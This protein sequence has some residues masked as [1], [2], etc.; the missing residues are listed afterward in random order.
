MKNY[1][2]Q[3]Q[4]DTV[5]LKVSYG[6]TWRG[7]HLTPPFHL[8]ANNEKEAEDIARQIIDPLN[9]CTMILTVSEE[10]SLPSELNAELRA[11]LGAEL[12]NA[13]EALNGDSKNAEHN[14]LFGLAKAVADV[15]G[16]NLYEL[17]SENEEDES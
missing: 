11:E 4:V 2:I 6:E 1:E 5:A 7:L 14:A 3:G 13:I 17:L 9:L 10:P 16:I 8:Q 15:L 12:D